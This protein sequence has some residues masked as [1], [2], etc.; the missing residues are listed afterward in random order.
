MCGKFLHEMSLVNTKVPQMPA[1]NRVNTQYF[2]T[3]PR[4]IEENMINDS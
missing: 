4:N 3:K 1:Q 2:V